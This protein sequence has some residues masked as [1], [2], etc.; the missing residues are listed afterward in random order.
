MLPRLI[1]SEDLSLDNAGRAQCRFL[2]PRNENINYFGELNIA[3]VY[4]VDINYI[5]V[6]ITSSFLCNLVTK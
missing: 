6:Q 5:A 4:L 2:Y 1:L 3:F